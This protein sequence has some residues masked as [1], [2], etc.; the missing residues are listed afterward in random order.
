MN[1][2]IDGQNLF[3]NNCIEILQGTIK[4][5]SI[6]KN[7]SGLEGTLTI[8]L[9]SQKRLIT[10]KGTISADCHNTLIKKIDDIEAFI[11]GKTHSLKQKS[12]KTFENVKMISFE[13]KPEQISAI[14]NSF[15]YK[16]I[17]E[18]LKV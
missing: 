7:V 3:D 6:E 5:N 12:G 8:D 2:T 4:R 17:Y 14:N 15:N 9:G 11:D 16:I 18:Q 1:V 10:Q 13:V